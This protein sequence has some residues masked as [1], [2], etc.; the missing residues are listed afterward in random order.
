MHALPTLI[1]CSQIPNNKNEIC[2]AENARYHEHLSSIS[3]YLPEFDVNADILLLLRT[4]VVGAHH[5]YDQVVGP[6]GAPFAQK[7]GLGWVV[8]VKYMH[9][10]LLM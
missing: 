6:P 8:L 10:I 7:L 2:T 9:E 3:D 1:E 4:D 5:V